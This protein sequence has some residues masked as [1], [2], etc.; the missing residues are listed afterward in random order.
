MLIRNEWPVSPILGPAPM[1]LAGE[2]AARNK[3]IARNPHRPGGLRRNDTVFVVVDSSECGST[4]SSPTPSSPRRL[5]ATLVP[6]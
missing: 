2:I 5:A 6:I 4:P 1:G 3:D